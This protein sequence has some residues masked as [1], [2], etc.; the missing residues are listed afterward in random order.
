M[1]GSTP[2]NKLPSWLTRTAVLVALIG[3]LV[4]IIVKVIDKVPMPTPTPAPGPT[5]TSSESFDLIVKVTDQSASPIASANVS[6]QPASNVTPISSIT[7]SDGLANVK[8]PKKFDGT[9]VTITIT[10]KDYLLYV[11]KVQVSEEMPPV[12]IQL[13]P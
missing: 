4:T 13:K 10:H 2:K 6:C 1:P 9:I 5:A 3:G 7:A 12:E 8:I 11:K